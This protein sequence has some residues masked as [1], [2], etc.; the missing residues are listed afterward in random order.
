MAYQKNPAIVSLDQLN[1]AAAAGVF[2]ALEEQQTYAISQQD[3][4]TTTGYAPPQPFEP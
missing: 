3:P 2:L 4:G 1:E